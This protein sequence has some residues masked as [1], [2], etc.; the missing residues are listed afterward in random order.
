MIV[1][2][3]C[4]S[5]TVTLGKSKNPNILHTSSVDVP[6]MMSLLALI[7]VG[8][9]TTEEQ[10]ALCSEL[11]RRVLADGKH[12]MRHPAVHPALLRKI[13]NLKCVS[14]WAYTC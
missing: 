10:T 6:L 4:V 2:E 9:A 5:L 1:L 14:K 11:A 7:R 13:S 8:C 12:D 3:G